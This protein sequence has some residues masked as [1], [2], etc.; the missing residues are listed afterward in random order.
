VLAACAACSTPNTSFELDVPKAVAAQAAWYE[1]GVFPSSCPAASLLLGGIPP[2]GTV[3]RV[4]FAAGAST[5]PALGVLPTESYGIAAVAR[6]SDCS[7]IATGCS[8][9]SVSGSASL[10]VSLT[11]IQGTPAGACSSGATCSHAECVPE[12]D[13]A[14]AVVGAACSLELVGQGP[15]ADPLF[16]ADED[17]MT[18][19]GAPAISATP[20]GFLVAYRELDP[21]TGAARLTTLAID[22]SGAAAAPV[23]TSLTGGCT[24]SAS[25]DATALVFTGAKGTIALSRPPCG[26]EG[27]NGDA[28]A[29][30]SGAGGVDLLTIDPTGAVQESAFNGENG[31]TLT[32]GQS[33]ALANTPAGVLLAYTNPAM[34]TSFAATVKGT[35][36][37]SSPAPIPFSQLSPL[38]LYSSAYVAGT[39]YGAAYLAVGASAA[40]AGASPQSMASVATAPAMGAD[41]GATGTSPFPAAW[42]S[43][44]GVGSRFLV[45]SNGSSPDGSI[46]WSAFDVGSSTPGPTGTFSPMSMGNVS[47]VDVAMHQDHAFFAAEVDQSLS[48]FAFDKASTSPVFLR[49]VPFSTIPSLPIGSLRDGLV[50][51]AASDTRVAVVWGTGQALTSDDDVGGYALFACVAP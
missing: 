33:H 19:L 34:Q 29:G 9:V 51:V 31:L 43:V 45:A 32:L 22:S 1:I 39:S 46:V 40:D 4:A 17:S 10:A 42:A 27:G 24:G 38:G 28:G 13:A 7:V 6:A 8:A 41:G 20:S 49:E 25:I 18:L 3:G 15:L 37:E 23:Q 14:S 47:F 26:I 44:S 16:A 11:A 48:L 36:L 30:G 12:A 35:A 5:P 50:A 21:G 2:Q